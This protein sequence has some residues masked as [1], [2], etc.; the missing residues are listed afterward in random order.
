MSWWSIFGYFHELIFNNN[1]LFLLLLRTI[2]GNANSDPDYQPTDY[3][4]CDGAKVVKLNT[5]KA[6]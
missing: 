5:K 1:Q 6:G 4:F 2:E 3:D